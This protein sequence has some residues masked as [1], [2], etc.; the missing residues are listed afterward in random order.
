MNLWNTYLLMVDLNTLID[1]YTIL[2]KTFLFINQHYKLKEH[3]KIDH[4]KIMIEKEEKEWRKTFSL[5][6]RNSVSRW[7]EEIK[8]VMISNKFCKMQLT[9]VWMTKNLKG[10]FTNRNL[11][12]TKLVKKKII[13]IKSLLMYTKNIRD[14]INNW[15]FKR[16]NWL[17]NLKFKKVLYKVNFKLKNKLLNIFRVSIIKVK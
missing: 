2:I 12:K 7:L 9:P 1:Q 14:L 10:N 15:I 17:P 11:I 5:I 13:K 8:I 3:L 16:A 6:K 4:L